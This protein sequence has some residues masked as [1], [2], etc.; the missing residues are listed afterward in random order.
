MKFFFYIF[1]WRE[2]HKNLIWKGTFLNLKLKGRRAQF[3]LSTQSTNEETMFCFVMIRGMCMRLQNWNSL[4]CSWNF[5]MIISLKQSVFRVRFLFTFCVCIFFLN[6]WKKGAKE[7]P[8]W[9]SIFQE[10]G[11]LVN[12]AK[13]NRVLEGRGYYTPSHFWRSWGSLWLVASDTRGRSS[14]QNKEDFVEGRGGQG[15]H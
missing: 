9:W 13:R 12:S 5:L 10:G 15:I 1:K 11:V 6:K 7:K 14:F 3:F 8:I 2:W 4:S